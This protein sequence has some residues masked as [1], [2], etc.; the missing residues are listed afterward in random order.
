MPS[1]SWGRLAVP[2]P[3][4][5]LLAVLTA[6]L[7]AVFMLAVLG[8]G[9]WADGVAETALAV[10]AALGLVSLLRQALAVNG[11]ARLPWLLMAGTVAGQG[12]WAVLVE[13]P[14]NSARAVGMH[15]VVT[16]VVGLALWLL[17]SPHLTRRGLV[18][19]VTDAA[20]AGFAFVIPAAQLVLPDGGRAFG[21]V[22]IV[23]HPVADVLLATI[24]VAVLA[25]SRHEGG[26]AVAPCVAMTLGAIVLAMSDLMAQA[27]VLETRC[28]GMLALAVMLW[29]VGAWLPGDGAESDPETHW[30]ERVAVL[31]PLAPLSAAAA[32]LLGSTVFDHQLSG[33]TLAAAVLLTATVVTGGVLARLDTLGTERTLDELVLKRT[34]TIGTR[35]KWFRS[36]V[37]NSS[38][39]ITVVDVRG[40][41]R[42]LTPSIMPILGH[43][44]KLLVG[45]RFTALLRPGDGRRLDAALATAARSPGRPITLDFPI[46]TKSGAWCDTETTVTSLVHDP[47]IRGLVLNT[48]DISERRRLEE[49]LTLQAYSDGL[50]GL[51]NRSLFR[52]KVE[53]A[54]KVALARAEVGVLFL[55][56]DGFKAVNDAQ[57]HHVGDELLGIVAK[58]LTNSVRPGDLVARLGGD[59]FAI[60]VTGPDAEE[61]AIWAAERVRRALSA[62]FVLDGRELALGASTGIAISDTGEETADQLLRNADLAM[63]RAKSRRD[64]SFVR[65]EAQMHDALLARMKAE[66]DLRQA[67]TRG[68][69][70]MYYQ[71]VVELSSRTVIGVEALV[72]WKHHERGIISPADFIDLAEE[73]GLVGEIG[74]WALEESCRQGARW[75]KHAGPG[76]HFKM[77]VNVSARQF[78]AT[79]P[80]QVRDILSSTGLPGAA[81]TLEMTESVLMERTDEVVELLRRM[82]TL[83]LKVAVDD[84]GTGYSSLSYLSRF[85]V[86]IL[87]IDKSFV[88]HL[89]NDSGK[90]ELVQT[91]V[92]LGESLRLD[93]VAEGIETTAQCE[94]LTAMGCIFGQG[95]LFSRPL[96]PEDIDALLEEQSR[97]RVP[98]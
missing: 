64:Q 6:A 66:S 94:A 89:G 63:Y 40:V 68:D 70:V 42:Y 30:R 2:A 41:V 8:R 61:G 78:D 85:P 79:L 33:V 35:E 59:E 51:A 49:Q 16:G 76:G 25:R 73:T 26:L 93:T 14:V 5:A 3:V 50:T 80:R 32:V 90:G 10:A 34:I 56:L 54:L 28:E 23:L 4:L 1:T 45:T 62:P 86:D 88:Q 91:I 65:F 97:L 95:Y 98:V 13:P 84:F 12:V 96:P 48:R 60:L 71:P 67:V 69:L 82:K 75:Q 72:R 83:G 11:R 43:D 36:L 55:D 44:P 22:G 29:T 20:A 19:L 46:W 7:V 87:K 47:D 92:R 15:L 39:V 38:D 27:G 53:T 74:R 9:T 37:Q 18:R 31:A 52:S 24:A 57:G 21:S 17:P 58:R 81:L 77:A